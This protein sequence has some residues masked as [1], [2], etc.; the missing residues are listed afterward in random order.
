MTGWSSSPSTM[1]TPVDD[2]TTFLDLTDFSVDF[3]S[4]ETMADVGAHDVPL[5][6]GP[7]VGSSASN[8]G[9]DPLLGLDGGNEAGTTDRPTTEVLPLRQQTTTPVTSSMMEASSL[10]LELHAPYL[11]HHHQQQQYQPHPQRRRQQQQQQYHRQAEYQRHLREQASRQPW[12]LPPTPNGSQTSGPSSGY[13]TPADLSTQSW[14]YQPSPEDQVRLPPP[15]FD[16]PRAEGCA[17][18]SD[19]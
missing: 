14:R 13:Y 2:F 10:E 12:V 3:S 4:L 7:L 18:R 17:P 16:S 8:G 9:P 1:A 6:L 15:P 5:G 19:R 11:H